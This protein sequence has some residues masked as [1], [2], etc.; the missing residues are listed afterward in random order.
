MVHLHSC[1]QRCIQ[2]P[3]MERVPKPFKTHARTPFVLV[4]V[5][6]TPVLRWQS[7]RVM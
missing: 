2:A 5:R 1:T 4:Q 7:R 6:P 3:V